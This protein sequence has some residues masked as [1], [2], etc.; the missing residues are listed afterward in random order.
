MASFVAAKDYDYWDKYLVG[1]I[2]EGSYDSPT[3]VTEKLVDF[4]Q[5]HL[6]RLSSSS[7]G[8][9][10][11]PL[12][13]CMHQWKEYPYG[14]AWHVWKPGSDWVD[15]STRMLK[16][17]NDQNIHIVGAAFAPGHLQLSAEGALVT[18]DNLIN[19][20]FTDTQP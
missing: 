8:D 6:S 1:D 17:G 16:P 9:L 18:V 15:I 4:L 2:F 5:K 7:V 19:T 12:Y 10:P 3:P 14:G 20:Y 13:A 11:R